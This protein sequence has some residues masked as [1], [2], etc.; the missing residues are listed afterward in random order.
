[1]PRCVAQGDGVSEGPD[2]EACE[3]GA[4][5]GRQL[6]LTI[7]SAS[8][9]SAGD[10]WACQ[11]FNWQVEEVRRQQKRNWAALEVHVTW[12]SPAFKG[13]DLEPPYN[14]EVWNPPEKRPNMPEDGCP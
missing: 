13:K 4:R 7:P 10:G 9:S 8:L 11:D 14:P 2:G 5:R 6:A 3:G 1:M 12:S